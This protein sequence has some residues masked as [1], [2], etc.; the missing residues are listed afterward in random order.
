MPPPGWILALDTATPWLALALW[1]SGDGRSARADAYL[2]RAI[3]GRLMGDVEAFLHLHDVEREAL[4]GIAVGVGPG[5]YTGVRIGIAAALGLGRSLAV[6]VSGSGTLEALA[7][8]A[9]SDGERGWSLLDARRE[10]AYALLARRVGDGLQ[11][12]RDGAPLPRS[13]LPDDGLARYEGHAPDARWHARSHRL[14]APPVAR[15]G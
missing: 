9:L 12:E 15:Y 10:R 4:V 2:G 5:S 11:V 7:F 3:A 14:W 13:E 1:H 6:P 8:A